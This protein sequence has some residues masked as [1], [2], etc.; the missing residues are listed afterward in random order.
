MPFTGRAIYDSDG[1]N[2]VFSGVAEDVSD[3]IS[4]ISPFETPLLDALQQ[5]TFPARNVL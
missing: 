5:A 1:T 3:V 2:V 4:M